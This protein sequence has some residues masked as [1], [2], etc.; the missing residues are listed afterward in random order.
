[1]KHFVGQPD[2][3]HYSKFY[4]QPMEGTKQWNTA[5]KWRWLCRNIGQLILNNF[6]FC[7]ISVR[8]TMQ[9]ELQ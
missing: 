2:P 4:L 1:M 5:R 9:S 3:E 7:E 6:K 8:Y